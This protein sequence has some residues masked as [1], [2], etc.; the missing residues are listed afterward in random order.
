MKNKL[1]TPLRT[2]NIYRESGVNA[3]AEARQKSVVP[4][5]AVPIHN[6]L[7]SD[8]AICVFPKHR[9]IAVFINARIPAKRSK[10]SVSVDTAF[11]LWYFMSD[12]SNSGL[13]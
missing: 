6:K 7:I 4:Q 11:C 12:I 10:R 8:L 3:M 5:I 1:G 13:S 2:L 9:A